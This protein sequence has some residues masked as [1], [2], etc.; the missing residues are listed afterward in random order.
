[1]VFFI[2][3]A[4]VAAFAGGIASV[5]GFGIGSLL[6]PLLTARYDMRTAVALVAI[7]HFIATAL[8][9]WTLRQYVDRRVLLGFGSMNAAGSLAGAL[10][11]TRL[12]SAILTIVLAI[13]LIFV[14]I[15]GVLGRASR[16][17][18]GKAEAWA[19]GIVSGAFGGLV[20]NQGGIRSAAMLGFGL[21]GAAFVATATAIA[22]VV[23]LV[24]MPVYFTVESARI[25]QA[26]PV[27]ATAIVG[28]VA[29]T[30][31]GARLLKRIPEKRFRFILSAILLVVGVLLLI[32]TYS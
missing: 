13:L 27:V 20:G 3:V 7:P 32:T 24:R 29:G 2:L 12:N 31:A 15:M 23:D 14:G 16:V 10:M 11:H 1:M 6:T 22:I 8:R 17:R 28:V 19:A 21:N 25:S 26:W 9:L 18:F 4:I 5:A 30:I